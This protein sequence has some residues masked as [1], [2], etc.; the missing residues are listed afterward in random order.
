MTF[1]IGHVYQ[2]KNFVYGPDDRQESYYMILV[3]EF[4][5]DMHEL[6]AMDLVT[7]DNIKLH[8]HRTNVH[9]FKKIESAEQLPQYIKNNG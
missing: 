1:E 6:F 8:V 4:F 3:S 5:R 7:G 2:Y 9:L